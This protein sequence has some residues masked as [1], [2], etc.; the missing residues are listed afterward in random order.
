MSHPLDLDLCHKWRQNVDYSYKLL[1]IAEIVTFPGD[2][3]QY[4]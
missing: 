4:D 3:R 1:F 2:Q